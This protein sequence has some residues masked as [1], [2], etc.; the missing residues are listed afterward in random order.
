MGFPYRRSCDPT[1]DGHRISSL[2]SSN[3]SSE[4]EE[5]RWEYPDLINLVK[6]ITPFPFNPPAGFSRT[7]LTLAFDFDAFG[8]RD[9]FLCF[10]E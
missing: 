5:R 2:H 8:I 7:L 10:W 9:D 6:S 1:C 4:K 3:I